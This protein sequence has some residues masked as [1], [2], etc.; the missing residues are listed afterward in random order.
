MSKGSLAKRGLLIYGRTWRFSATVK[1]V[2]G[3]NHC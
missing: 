3:I 2:K 1:S